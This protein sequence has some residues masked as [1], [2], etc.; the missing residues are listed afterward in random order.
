MWID[1]REWKLVP[2]EPTDEMLYAGR[3][4]IEDGGSTREVFLDMLAAA[5]TPPAQAS[6]QAP[7]DEEIIADMEARG[8]KYMDEEERTDIIQSFR[9]LFARYGQAS[10]ASVC[11]GCEGDPTPENDPCAVC[12]KP[13]ASAEPVLR[14]YAEGSMRSVTEWLD[15]ARDLPDGDHTLYAAP[16][17]AQAPAA[18]GDAL[19]DYKKNG[20]AAV[21][22]A[23]SSAHWSNELRRLFGSDARDGIDRLEERLR[24]AEQDT[25][26]WRF[27]R[28]KLCLTG[29][30]DGTCAM[31]AI[32]LPAA[33]QGWPEPE[34]VAEFCD[35]AIDD[36]MGKE[37]K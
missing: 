28:R 7:S 17:A 22:F 34:Q 30:G 9:V 32:N 12:G 6:G 21:R 23:P 20:A 24:A 3:D 15:G 27:I 33:I 2:V 35:A 8:W 31:Q 19:E 36:A 18:D 10:A 25:A 29:N 13:A 5:P 26:R 14:I 4:A 11:V 1:G 37:G 16:V